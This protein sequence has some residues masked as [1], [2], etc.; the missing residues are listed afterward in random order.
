MTGIDRRTA[1]AAALCA[2]SGV[3][4]AAATRSVAMYLQ[5]ERALQDALDRRDRQAVA[6][7]LADDFTWRSAA[8]ADPVSADQWLEREMASP[9]AEA[10]VR[11]LSVR[12][13]D[14]LAVVTFLL[15]HRAGSKTATYFVVDLWRASTRRLLGRSI[16]RAAGAPPPPARPSG[17]E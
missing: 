15:D 12:E 7:L 14:D 2:A 4:D 3:A 5:L 8:A 13:A 11:D 1:L 6:A 9:P 10:L 17:R 16:T